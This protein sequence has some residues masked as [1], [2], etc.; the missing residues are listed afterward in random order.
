[1]RDGRAVAL[2]AAGGIAALAIGIVLGSGPL[3]SA[4][5]GDVGAQ[6]D[7]LQAQVDDESAARAAAEAA[8]DGTIAY[9]DGVA[10]ALLAGRLTGAGVLVV[11]VPGASGELA[12]RLEDRIVL[13]GGEVTGEAALTDQWADEGGATFRDALAEQVSATV[14]G[15]PAVDATTV[16]AHAFVQGATGAAPSGTDLAAVDAAGADRGPVLWSLLMQAG[17]ATGDAAVRTDL[18]VL[19]GGSDPAGLAAL[20]DAFALYDAPVM[21]AGSPSQVAPYAGAAEVAT[22]S[23][24]EWTVGSVTAAAA[25]SEAWGG[26]VPHYAEGDVPEVLGASPVPPGTAG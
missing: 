21:V 8:A 14:V 23:G 17:L 1:M 3:R 5:L 6:I 25:L 2:L 12:A 26:F 11:T 24:D 22:V 16:L 18:V 9:V 20:A 13:A 10:P 4:L 15:A 7:E 19:V